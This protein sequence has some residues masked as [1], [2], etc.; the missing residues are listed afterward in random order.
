M[1]LGLG[2][3]RGNARLP[4]VAEGGQEALQ[5]GVGGEHLLDGRDH[6]GGVQPVERDARPHRPERQVTLDVLL[7]LLV[8]SGS[9]PPPFRSGDERAGAHPGRQW[10]PHVLRLV[11]PQ[12]HP[13]PEG[14]AGHSGG[15]AQQHVRG[16]GPGALHGEVDGGQVE[17]LVAPDLGAHPAG[18]RLVVL[19]EAG[20]AGGGGGHRTGPGDGGV[21]GHADSDGRSRADRTG[22]PLARRVGGRVLG[23]GVGAQLGPAGGPA[24]GETG[25]P[26][27]H[28]VRAGRTGVRPGQ[29][30]AHD[31]VAQQPGHVL[32]HGRGGGRRVQAGPPGGAGLGERGVQHGRDR[33]EQPAAA[34]VRPGVVGDGD[35]GEGT[36]VPDAPGQGRVVDARRRWRRGGVV[37]H[38]VLGR[39]SHGQRAGAVHGRC[40]C[41]VLLPDPHAVTHPARYLDRPRLAAQHPRF[42]HALLAAALLRRLPGLGLRHAHAAQVEAR[43]DGGEP[44]EGAARAVTRRAARTGTHRGGRVVVD[45]DLGGV[46]LGPR[47]GGRLDLRGPFVGGGGDGDGHVEPAPPLAPLDG[48]R[49]ALPVER[50]GP[51]GQFRRDLGDRAVGARDGA[52]H[53][54][55]DELVPGEPVRRGQPRRLEAQQIR[56]EGQA[57]LG[58][59]RHG[60]QARPARRGRAVGRTRPHRPRGPRIAGALLE[61]EHVGARPGPAGLTQAARS[62][63]PGHRGRPPTGAVLALVRLPLSLPLSS[64]PRQRMDAEAA[65]R[66]T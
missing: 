58:G 10:Q 47:E 31:A 26:G 50:L 30:V 43:G 48:E 8:A 19:G 62:F 36:G 1:P 17:H 20:L 2:L 7:R 22:A 53:D 13:H 41:R 45:V 24:R 21:H 40:G 44:E 28:P 39:H 42:G 9:L 54:G 3:G 25:D 33:V 49:A 57:V 18:R 59:L 16:T 14:V 4:L 5:P 51:R 35:G 56:G 23:V 66:G 11:R 52:G 65:V 63:R 64:H 34:R 61:R 12:G 29:V 6:A 60:A 27:A 46:L 32:Q 15:P 37:R 55:A 38:E